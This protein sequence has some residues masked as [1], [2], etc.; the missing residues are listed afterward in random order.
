MGGSLAAEAAT[1]VTAN[2][3]APAD[4]NAP[5]VY[6]E[7][8]KTVRA[9]TLDI[10]QKVFDYGGGNT[11]TAWTYNGTVPG[12]TMHVRPGEILRVHDVHGGAW[13]RPCTSGPA[14]SCA[15]T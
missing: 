10:V 5:K 11:W 13:D 6:K 2:L 3:P 9:Y 7:G 1:E 4:R 12:P 15:C 14:R 8:G